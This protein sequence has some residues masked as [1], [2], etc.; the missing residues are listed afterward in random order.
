M[1]LDPDV[2]TWV[3]V[4]VPAD[5][6]LWRADVGEAFDWLGRR[7]AAAFSSVGVP[8]SVH[9]GPYE[10]GP[11]GGMVCFASLGPGEVAV[12]GRKLVGISQ[13]RS[14]EGSRFQCVAYERFGL[15]PMTP[16]L[17]ADT[18]AQVLDRA[19][20]W[21]DLGIDV[22][23]TGLADLVVSFITAHDT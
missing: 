9:R 12:D 1:W 13:R 20:G 21:A 18:A 6:P 19:V 15:G 22:T 8:A 14:R 3:D 17:D 5:D 2:C 23:P 16:L 10:T 4:F 7:L 11:S